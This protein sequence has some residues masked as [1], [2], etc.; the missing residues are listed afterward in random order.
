MR[1]IDADAFASVLKS[2][3]DS[4]RGGDCNEWLRGYVDGLDAV[5][6]TLLGFDTII[7]KEA[8]EQ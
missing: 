6:R 5:Y 1:P 8:R 7:L 4:L 3:A 2:V